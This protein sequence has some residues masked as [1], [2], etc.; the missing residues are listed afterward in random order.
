MSIKKVAIVSFVISYLVFLIA[1]IPAALVTQLLTLPKE[2]RLGYVS[3]T[4]WRSEIDSI[5]YQDVVVNKISAKLSPWSLLIFSPNITTQ[6][7]SAQHDGPKGEATVAASLN[8]LDISNAKVTLA[9]NELVPHL[10]LPMPIEGFGQL[11]LDIE[12]FTLTDGQCDTLA[13]NLRWQRAAV[14]AMEQ[15]IELGEFSGKLSC[16]QQAFAL[17]VLANN[18]LGLS[19]QASADWQGNI[20]GKG[21][22]LPSDDFPKELRE[23]LPFLGNPDNQGRYQLNLP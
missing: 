21:F 23:V 16:Q 17:E 10:P 6:F 19:Y 14:S 8:S 15:T 11:N 12:N 20:K 9:V 3:G 22:I 2:V 1:N 18:R 7:G 4:L 5:Q 13:G